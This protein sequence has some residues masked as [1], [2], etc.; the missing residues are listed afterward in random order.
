M[1]RPCA[2]CRGY[3]LE[4][5]GCIA[6]AGLGMVDLQSKQ[7]PSK[8]RAAGAHQMTPAQQSIVDALV[9]PAPRDTLQSLRRFYGV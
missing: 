6:C 4:R 7:D 2:D 5:R 1:K 3:E 9:D 8:T